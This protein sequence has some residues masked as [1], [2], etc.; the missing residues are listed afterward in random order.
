[1]SGYLPPGVS[2]SDPTAPWNQPDPEDCPE[3]FGTGEEPDHTNTDCSPIEC[4]YC[5]G[6]G[7]KEEEDFNEYD[8]SDEK[9][10]TK[11]DR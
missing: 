6:T 8:L 11:N 2:E 5:D 7:F 3:C 4:K 10:E 9:Y 1:M